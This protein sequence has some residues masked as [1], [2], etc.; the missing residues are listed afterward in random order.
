MAGQTRIEREAAARLRTLTVDVGKEILRQR[1]DAGVS[2]TALAAAAA[3]D[4]SH[5]SRI[6]RALVMPSVGTLTRLAAALGGELAVRVYPGTGPRIHDRIQA[7]MTEA[8][9]SILHPSWGRH[10]EVSVQRPVRGVIDAVLVSPDRQLLVATE[11]ESGLR[12]LEQQ[13]RW[14]SEKAAALAAAG[15]PQFLGGPTS[16]PAPVSRLLVLQSTRNSRDVASTFEHT[17][18]TAYPAAVRDVLEALTKPAQWPGAGML[19]ATIDGRSARILE[20]PPRGVR[21]GR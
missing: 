21:L 12:R 5:L 4:R 10:L 6:E 17:L 20:G 14:S 11:L 15:L 19:W 8:V 16:A 9:L 18:R 7:R 3:I 1:L 2:Q 13:I